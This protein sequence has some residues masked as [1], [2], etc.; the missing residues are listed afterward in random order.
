LLV[1]PHNPIATMPKSFFIH[2]FCL[3]PLCKSI[4]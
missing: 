4:S 1:V 3:Q 2:L